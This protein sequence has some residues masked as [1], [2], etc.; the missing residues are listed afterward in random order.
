[1]DNEEKR[2]PGWPFESVE[3]RRAWATEHYNSVEYYQSRKQ[4]V[5]QIE[6]FLRMYPTKDSYINRSQEAR[7]KEYAEYKARFPESAEY[8]EKM[9]PEQKKALETDL[10]AFWGPGK[11][12]DSRIERYASYKRFVDEYE[13]GIRSRYSEDGAL[14]YYTPDGTVIRT[15]RKGDPIE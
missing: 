15:W 10:D 1:M 11:Q 4:S 6:E 14:E 5:E 7:D 13:A 12:Y 9:D 3:A 2:W 8:F